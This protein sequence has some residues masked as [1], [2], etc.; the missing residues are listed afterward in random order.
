VASPQAITVFVAIFG[1]VLGPMYGIMVADY[2]WV[3]R[4]QVVL[5]DLY[6]APPSGSFYFEAG[7]NRSAL[8]ALGVAGLLSIGLALLGNFGVIYNVGDWGWLIGA[9]AGAIVHYGLSASV[10]AVVKAARA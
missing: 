7:W 4:R 2:Y 5:N 8:I 6:T 10:A 9:S 1:A 3:K